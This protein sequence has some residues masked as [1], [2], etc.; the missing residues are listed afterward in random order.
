MTKN[1]RGFTLIELLV[2]IAIIGI[3]ASI[4]LVSLNSA[5]SKGSDTRILSDVQQ[6]R[7]AVE[8]GY[9]GST[10]GD[11]VTLGAQ[12]SAT[13]FGTTT[14]GPNA[15]T[16]LALSNDAVSQGGKV[17]VITNAASPTAYAI[18]GQLKS[19]GTGGV[20][21]FFCIDSTG[22]TNPSYSNATAPITVTCP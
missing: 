15:A 13:G 21:Q 7:T 4:V 12:N 10:W 20:T 22:K 2:V 19:L 11:L 8:A 18:Y 9:N 1:T 5:R 17:Y 6:M 3:L 14:A 16:T